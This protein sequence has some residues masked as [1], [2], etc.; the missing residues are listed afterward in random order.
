[1]LTEKNLH[2]FV[3]LRARNQEWQYSL[4]M[5]CG[6]IIWEN[7]PS[8][9]K[10]QMSLGTAELSFQGPTVHISMSESPG[11]PPVKKLYQDFLNWPHLGCPA[12]NPVSSL[13]IMSS[14]WTHW[15]VQAQTRPEL[16][17]SDFKDQMCLYQT[18][19]TQLW[20]ENGQYVQLP[21]F[22]TKQQPTKWWWSWTACPGFAKEFSSES[23]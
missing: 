15:E 13:V 5:L 10:I 9:K 2:R 17:P 14:Q 7:V 11:N 20:Y 22:Q 1:M 6:I 3:S 18:P 19:Q 21:T 4:S 16:R 8:F 12:L 23:S